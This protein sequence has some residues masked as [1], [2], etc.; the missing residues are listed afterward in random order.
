MRFSLNASN[1]YPPRLTYLS[2]SSLSHSSL[3]SLKTLLYHLAALLQLFT[4]GNLLSNPQRE[5]ERRDRERHELEKRQYEINLRFE[6]AAAKSRQLQL[7]REAEQELQ[8]QLEEQERLL[9]QAKAQAALGLCSRRSFYDYE[10]YNQYSSFF[11]NDD[12]D[13]SL[14]YQ[15]YTATD[16]YYHSPQRPKKEYTW[17]E[18]RKANKAHTL[19]TPGNT[20]RRKRTRKGKGDLLESDYHAGLSKP[21]I[22]AKSSERKADFECQKLRRQRRGSSVPL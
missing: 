7:E 8:H 14:E 22:L 17:R 1:T 6:R 3:F 18:S 16:E 13:T 12:N 19:S 2:F 4:M 15:S 11:D 9:L 5:R 21:E 10:P 20:G